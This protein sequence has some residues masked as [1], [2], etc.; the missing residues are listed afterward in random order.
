M[1]SS[2]VSYVTDSY[3][4]R[5]GEEEVT[6][7]IPK[8]WNVVAAKK[9]RVNRGVVDE[10]GAI[11]NALENPIGTNQLEDIVANA[12]TVVIITDDKYRPTP[13][14]KILPIL[15]KK[16]ND[17]GVNDENITIVAGSGT[18]PHLTKK[19]LEWKYGTKLTGR[20]K[21]VA[22]D[23]HNNL[24]YFGESKKG[25]PVWINKTVAEADVKI[26]VGNIIP[27]FH[28]GFRGGA[29][30]I[31]PG[32]SGF[33]SIRSNHFLIEEYDGPV[34]GNVNNPI[35]QDMEDIAQNMVHLDFLVNT[36]LNPHK[37]IV[38]VVA[39]DV[40]K[41]HRK[42]AQT[43][44]EIFR[45]PIPKLA[46]VVITSTYPTDEHFS[47]AW[48]FAG[49][50]LPIMKKGGTVIL[51]AP[52]KEGVDADSIKI[53][54][55]RYK[56]VSAAFKDIKDGT[57]VL[58]GGRVA[59][60]CMMLNFLQNNEV[61]FVT[62]QEIRGDIVKMG[63]RYASTINEAIADAYQKYRAADVTIIP[64]GYFMYPVYQPS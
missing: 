33:T 41:A 54:T 10:E 19:D 43:A 62:R 55:R 31:L 34:A 16:L 38:K 13:V 56:T 59:S 36:V 25:T 8:T 21:T 63:F 37:Q 14:K 22:H 44:N 11:V 47:H 15:L 3:K 53:L 49:F 46:D 48:N 24:V 64:S 60:L 1:V 61:T 50:M 7:Q 9:L 51:S 26:G 18:H 29:K 40:V 17:A 2:K 52:C 58:E 39:G 12:K 35:R 5:Y 6:F 45:M 23:P 42:G 28:T 32:V 30:I 20:I 27:A 57:L 4:I